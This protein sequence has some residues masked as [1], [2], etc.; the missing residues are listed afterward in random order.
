LFPDFNPFHAEI[1]SRKKFFYIFMVSY[2]LSLQDDADI[3][4]YHRDGMAAFFSLI[5][6]TKAIQGK[7]CYNVIHI[8]ATRKVFKMNI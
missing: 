3:M 6:N 2:K 8:S 5:P 7:T 4:K 1:L